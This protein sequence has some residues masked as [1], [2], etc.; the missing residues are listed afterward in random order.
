M[1]G[2]ARV[3]LELKPDQTKRDVSS[4]SCDVFRCT[5]AWDLD[6]QVKLLVS[7]HS[8]ISMS[9]QYREG[10]Q[11]LTCCLPHPL[12]Q[13]FKECRSWSTIRKHQNL[14]LDVCHPAPHTFHRSCSFLSPKRSEVA[15]QLGSADCEQ[16]APL[17]SRCQCNQHPGVS[18][19]QAT[20][21]CGGHTTCSCPS[22]CSLTHV[23]VCQHPELHLD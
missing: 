15:T 2:D 19:Q 23:D 21:R 8:S 9:P 20:G 14:R 4:A 18:C 16:L 10:A 1:G 12:S 6:F 22:L 5:G 17:F 11:S 13:H 3:G 7:V